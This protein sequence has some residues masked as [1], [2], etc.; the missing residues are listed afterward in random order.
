MEKARTFPFF[1][2]QAG[3]GSQGSARGTAPVPTPSVSAATAHLRFKVALLDVNGAELC[4]R[5]V[6]TRL[7]YSHHLARRC[8]ADELLQGLQASAR[9]KAGQACHSAPSSG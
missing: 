1:L 9:G 2:C 3:Q 7:A 6:E 5:I 8:L 4:P